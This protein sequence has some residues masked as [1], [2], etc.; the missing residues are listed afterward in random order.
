MGS[1]LW[2]E[3]GRRL[4]VQWFDA[5]GRRRQETVRA[6]SVTGEP[7]SRRTVERDGRRRLAEHEL[8][9]DRQR[10][11]LAPI[12]SDVLDRPLRYLIEWWWG[13]R[14]KA[15][16]SPAILPFIRKHLGTML[17]R[18]LREVT[19]VDLE[20]LIHTDLE[21]ALSPKSR[22][23]LRGY[24]HAA[25]AA[26][27]KRGGPWEGR[28]N[29]VAD[30]PPVSVP[31]VPRSILLPGE[32]EPVLQHVDPE[33]RGPT[34]AALYAGLREGEV[35]GLR[36]TDVDLQ[37]GV[38]LVSRSWDAPRTKDGKPRPVVIAPPLAPYL[39]A[40]LQSPGEMLF[41]DAKGKARPR[42]LRLGKQLRRAIAAA[43]LLVGY[44]WR[45]RAW[46]CGWRE[47][48]PSASVPESCPKCGRS[49]TWAR[50][51][52]RHVRFHDT[53]HSFGTAMVRAAGLA[54][55]QRGLGHSD[56]RLT[57]DTYGH[58]D[59]DDLRAGTMRAFPAPAQGG[60]PPTGPR[61][62]VVAGEAGRAPMAAG[63]LH[64]PTDEGSPKR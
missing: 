24:L 25:Y 1:L 16:K 28:T 13:H 44:E 57:A 27:R 63:R 29:P 49:T 3:G 7:L 18:P 42:T 11:G 26:A 17:G 31:R 8:E 48:Q 35:F 47:R 34:A 37:A 23:H 53:R 45:C 52:P 19:P 43:G 38:I 62:Q 39:A 56:V 30:V 33:W 50:P 12:S 51:L 64:D 60:A 21:P 14:G 54:V 2:R 9:A 58:L 41:P 15:L 61:L 4:V 10:A 20:R 32:M 36:K 40:A 46:R 22:K 6:Q 5:A 55:A 59:L